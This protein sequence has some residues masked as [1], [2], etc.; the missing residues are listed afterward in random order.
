[1]ERERSKPRIRSALWRGLRRRCPHCGRGAM[2][3]TWFR[4]RT[5]CSVCRLRFEQRPGDTWA[6]WII[7]DRLFVAA[8][9]VV[10]VL[11]F[12]STSVAHALGLFLAAS[13]PLIWTW[14]HRLGFCVGLDYLSRVYLGQPSD[15]PPFPDDI[16]DE[17]T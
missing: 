2:F 6:F 15:V 17:T 8:V 10:V 13:V 14:P 4:L 1:M 7:G 16:D 12:R 5:E 9:L 3:R 11:G